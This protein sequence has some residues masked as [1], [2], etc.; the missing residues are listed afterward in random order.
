MK[1]L[2]LLTLMAK[3]GLSLPLDSSMQDSSCGLQWFSKVLADLG[4]SQD[5]AQ[6]LSTFSGHVHRL[7][8]ITEAVDADSLVLLDEVRLLLPYRPALWVWARL[9]ST[10][11][12]LCG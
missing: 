3:A 11:T 4:D 12:L 10:L 6:N 5:L 7:K 8:R 1:T 2:G 9:S